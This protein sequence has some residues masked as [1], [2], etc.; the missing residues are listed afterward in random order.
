MIYYYI[1]ILQIHTIFYKMNTNL[2]FHNQ[3]RF[4]VAPML[5]YTDEFCNY[6]HRKLTKK[7]ILYTEMMTTRY[8]LN[9]KKILKKNYTIRLP[10]N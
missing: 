2:N 8:I 4:C 9:K 1:I 5:N 3:N 6:F 7:S 10:F